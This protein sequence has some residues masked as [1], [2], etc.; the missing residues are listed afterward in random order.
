MTDIFLHRQI[1]IILQQLLKFSLFFSKEHAQLI[2]LK[3]SVLAMTQ[4]D[5]QFISPNQGRTLEF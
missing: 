5:D 4:K 1:C 2:L 3:I